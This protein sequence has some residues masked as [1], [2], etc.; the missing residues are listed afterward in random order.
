MCCD[1]ETSKLGVLLGGN[2]LASQSLTGTFWG[3]IVLD[4]T[5]THLS[6]SIES[7]RNETW[8]SEPE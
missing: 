1:W 5:Y 8:L 2:V 6:F 7:Y 3:A 4:H